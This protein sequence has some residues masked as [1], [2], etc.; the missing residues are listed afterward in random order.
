[1]EPKVSLKERI[2]YQLDNL[3]SRGT[4]MVILTLGLVSLIVITIGAL[5]I[6]YS[7][8]APGDEPGYSLLE[9][10]WVSMLTTIGEGSIGGR[11]TVWTYRL[12]IFTLT[13]ASIFITSFLI[14]ALT[15]GLVSRVSEL[16]KGRSKVIESG[17]TVILGWSEQVFTIISELMCANASEPKFTIAILGNLPKEEMEEQIKQK[18]VPIGRTKVVCR[19]GDPMEMADLHIISLETA[20]NVIIVQPDTSQADAEVIKI[21]LA[22]VNNPARRK[23]PYH[24]VAGIRN[25]RNYEVARVAGKDEVQWIITSD[26]V[27]RVLAQTNL[28]PGLSV[29]YDEL[30]DFADNEIYL[31]DPGG[32]AGETFGQALFAYEDCLLIG[33][34]DGEGEVVLNPPAERVIRKSDRL[35]IIAVD[36]KDV[37]LRA[38]DTIPLQREAIIDT[39]VAEPVAK[40]VLI[41][42]WNWRGARIVQ[43]LDH[44]IPPGSEV[45]VI[46]DT[47]KVE[48]D[49]QREC[50]ML[51]RLKVCYYPGDTDDRQVLEGLRLQ[52]FDHIIL[53]GY[54]DTLAPQR[55]DAK[56]LVTLL[57]LRDIKE[58]DGSRFTVVTELMDLRN[59]DLAATARAD[60]YVV[61]DRLVSLFMAQ[62]AENAH[63][64]NVFKDLLDTDTSEIYLKP[65][66]RYVEPGRPVNFYTIMEAARLRSEVS[67]GFRVEAHAS[68]PARDYGVVINPPKAVD[69]TFGVADKIIV[70]ADR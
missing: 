11:E 15:N 46:A 5:F 39:P 53:L 44:Y 68:D 14:S 36:N 70:I 12:L 33:V 67:L 64:N 55:A 7:R 3:Y 60:D 38:S 13:M 41:L 1:M 56:T 8:L 23:E 62:V 26:L 52:R 45:T 54:S 20:K 42:G 40:Q 66:S 43:E 6:L 57:H 50:S 27:A 2:R 59:Y 28:Q 18:V 22:I 47:D 31:I 4:G 19:T 58:R 9:A 29:V 69:Y 61:S 63:L 34:C 37:T 17:H 10:F 32:L 30:F 24:I 65:V 51:F 16:K 25:P 48:Q 35:I 49:I 21:V